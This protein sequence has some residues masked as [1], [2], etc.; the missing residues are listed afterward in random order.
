MMRVSLHPRKLY[1]VLRVDHTYWDTYL[2]CA[3]WVNNKFKWQLMRKGSWV[4][5]QLSKKLPD[6]VDRWS[7]LAQYYGFGITCGKTVSNSGYH[8]VVSDVF[9]PIN[10]DWLF[11]IKCVVDTP[12][13]NRELGEKLVKDN[14]P[15]NITLDWYV[16][17]GLFKSV[18]L[19]RTKAISASAI[20]DFTL[21]DTPFYIN[22]IA[23]YFLMN[24]EVEG[25]VPKEPRLYNIHG[26]DIYAYTRYYWYDEGNLCVLAY[27]PEQTIYTDAETVSIGGGWTYITRDK[28]CE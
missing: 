14:F 6:V 8:K 23:F 26:L 12:P 15:E 10:N 21:H 20:I 1:P 25:D 13:D 3:L 17:S 16:Q 18:I 24:P 4:P 9:N 11:K 2:G 7:V 28:D 22:G 19:E 5:L 27:L